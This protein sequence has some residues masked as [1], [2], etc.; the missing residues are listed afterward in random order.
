M[1]RIGFWAQLPPNHPASTGEGL[2]WPSE[3]YDPGWDE[4]ERLKVATYLDS[5]KEH[6]AY[7]GW[8]SCR[9]CGISNGSRELTDGKYLWPSGYSHYVRDH[10]IRPPQSFIDHV[11]KSFDAEAIQ[12]EAVQENLAVAK[13]IAGI[14]VS[15]VIS[16]EVNPMIMVDGYQLQSVN[17]ISARRI[18]GYF[19]QLQ[20]TSSDWDKMT[21]D[22]KAE[23][24]RKLTTKMYGK[25]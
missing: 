16:P 14:D 13:K 19:A 17:E 8:S 12:I 25:S 4:T 24:I 10:K 23:A 3:F 22:Q 2:P 15:E 20:R 9:L 6:E 18:D 21:F 5:G 1:I 7:L 11:L